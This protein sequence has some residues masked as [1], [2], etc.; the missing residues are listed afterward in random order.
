MRIPKAILVLIVTVGFAITATAPAFAQEEGSPSLEVLSLPERDS[1]YRAEVIEIYAVTEQQTGK[2]PPTIV[3]AKLLEGPERLRQVIINLHPTSVF[4]VGGEREIMAGTK[5]VVGQTRL[6]GKEDFYVADHYRISALWAIAACF[7]LLVIAVSRWKGLASMLG[8][9]FTAY[10][11]VGYIMPKIA[12]GAGPMR[13]ALPALFVIAIVSIYMAHGLNRR[14]HVAV[15]C[16]LATMSLAAVV[17][18]LMA[19]GAHLYGFG[20]ED[21]MYLQ[22]TDF[23]SIDFQGLFLV[24]VIIGALGVLDDVT[25]GQ[26]AVIDELVMANPSLGFTELWK[27]GLSVGKEHISSLVNTLFLAYAGVSLPLFLLY[28]A[29]NT[30]PL[31][32]FLNGEQMAEEIVRTLAGSMALVLAVP[33]TTAVAALILRP[34]KLEAKS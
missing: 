30:Q 2:R 6:D 34:K 16:T 7:F 8:L 14:T 4:G 3:R 26:A 11:L 15:I 9:A 22:H 28:Q 29:N 21:A 18:S 23:A 33:L 12:A 20:E 19:S 1:F 31:W 32:M 24:G 17:S 13:T 27:R 25:T 5:V 10:A